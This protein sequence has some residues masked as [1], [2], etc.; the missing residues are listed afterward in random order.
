MEQANVR[1]EALDPASED[2]RATPW[3]ASKD[4]LLI[5]VLF[6]T[7]RA[8]ALLVYRPGGQ[9]LDF[10]DFYWYREYA[11]VTRQGY[12]PYVNLWAPYPPLF[13][14]LV[15]GLWWISTLL[16]PWEF[17]NLWFTLALGGTMLL[18]ETA[19]LVLIFCLAREMAGEGWAQR[20]AWFYLGLFVPVYTLTAHFES[21]PLFFFLLGLYLLLRRRSVSSALLTGLG[22]LTKLLPFLLIPV[23]VRVVPD[24]PD[25]GE[26]PGRDAW[27]LSLPRLNLELDARHSLKY[28]AVFVITV[29]TAAVPLYLVNPRLVWASLVINNVREP[30]QTVWALL[31]GNY[32]YGIAPL[33][34]RDLDW[35]PVASSGATLP[36]AWIS[37][38]F[39]LV[40]AWMY[41]RRFD[42]RQPKNIVAFTGFTVMLFMLYSKGYSPQWLG[43]ALV[44]VALLLPN[45]RG[46]VYACVVT[47]VNYLEANVFFTMLPGEHWLMVVT[48]CVRTIVFLMLGF[49]FVLILMPRWQTRAV[50]RS[51]RLLLVGFVLVLVVGCVPAS[52]RFVR[53]YTAA[54]LEMS[55]Y[56]TTIEVLESGAM[57]GSALWLNAYDHRTYDWLYPYL[58]R[59]M[60]FY[61][62]D[63][64]APASQTVEG[65]TRALL[66]RAT[67]RHGEWWVFDND[68]G[69][70]SAPETILA[71][72]LERH[73]VQVE[74]RDVDGGRLYRYDVRP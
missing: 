11:Q 56:R 63:D 16:P 70:T 53:S 46:A 55:P 40:F 44:F 32:R 37:L 1:G 43:W 73:G 14:F 19:N 28:L 25:F 9:V 20:S 68:V 58:R 64:Y 15:V 6:V 50:L 35:Q 13:P 23:A 66:E 34:M 72:W 31:V 21:L 22:F 48:V 69:D 74:V 59:Q 45:L 49:E 36:W 2:G 29:M 7:F 42:W 33:D 8:M 41:T 65:R 24:R 5:L 30:W 54:R 26:T 71:E 51:R 47:V 27:R 4:F 39:G 10:S 38:A 3:Y 67:Q 57:P 62:L 18:F 52:V 12:V 61:M 17:A 60:S